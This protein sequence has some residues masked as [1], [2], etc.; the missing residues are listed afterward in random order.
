MKPILLT[1]AVFCGLASSAPV[2]AT[3]I[4]YRFSLSIIAGAGGGTMT[5]DF[6]YD[7]VTNLESIVSITIAGNTFG[8]GSTIDLTFTQVAPITP[9]AVT[10]FFNTASDIILGKDGAAQAFLGVVAPLTAAGGQ[11]LLY[12]AIDANGLGF[13]QSSVDG[14]GVFATPV[15]TTPEPAGLGVISVGLMGLALKRRRATP[16][17]LARA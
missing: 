13:Q 7:P 1:A 17:A 3:P 8:S 5:G 2:L 10:P 9:P 14:L 11:I 4:E 16:A 12:G 15:T 6:D